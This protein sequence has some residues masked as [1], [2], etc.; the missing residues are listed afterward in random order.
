MQ[1]QYL[2]LIQFSAPRN[3]DIHYVWYLEEVTVSEQRVVGTTV[4]DRKPACKTPTQ[5]FIMDSG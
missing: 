2:G 4:S 5:K 1:L 3:A